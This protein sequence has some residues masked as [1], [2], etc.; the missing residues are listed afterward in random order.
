MVKVP[1]RSDGSLTEVSAVVL[2]TFGSTSLKTR[3]GSAPGC[4]NEPLESGLVSTERPAFPADVAPDILNHW[5]VHR[6]A[7][8]PQ[9]CLSA[10]TL[11]QV[12]NGFI[13]TD[14]PPPGLMEARM[15]ESMEHERT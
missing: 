15:R 13:D 2:D 10:E 12:N 11:R 14:K 1:S 6:E 5:S 3:R 9:P 4:T 8:P 7:R